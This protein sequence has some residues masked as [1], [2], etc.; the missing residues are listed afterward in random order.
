MNP[1]VYTDS[2]D[3]GSSGLQSKMLLMQ[4]CE[5]PSQVWFKVPTTLSESVY[6][7]SF[8]PQ[9]PEIQVLPYI[10]SCLLY[11]HRQI[12]SALSGVLYFDVECPQKV[13]V[14]NKILVLRMALLGSTEIFEISY[15]RSLGC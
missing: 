13:H 6:L 9:V 2:E 5:V 12:L 14:L 7:I 4:A 11:K 1:A 15:G 8:Y 3:M 10:R